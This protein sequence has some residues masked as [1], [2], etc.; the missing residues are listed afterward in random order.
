MKNNN[1]IHRPKIMGIL[2]VTPDS[3]S[4]GGKHNQ[5]M[6]A[7]DRVLRMLDQG[8][9]IIDIGG[10]STRPGADPVPAQEQ[11]NRVIPVIE[12]IRRSSK[13]DTLISVD[14]T[15]YLVATFALEAGANWINDVSAGEDS[16]LF[17]NSNEP[18][19]SLAA[20]KNVPIILMHSQGKSINMQDDPSYTDVCLE[21][22][23]Y[24]LERAKVALKMGVKKENIILD[25]GI[26]FGKLLKH[27]LELL[28]DLP[29]FTSMGYP[30]LL[31]TSRKRFIGEI[32]HQNNPEKRVAGTCATTALGVNAGVQIFRVH[33]IAENR[34]AADVAWQIKNTH[35]KHTPLFY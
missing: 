25:P 20:R 9:D 6:Q 2:N 26:G 11:I 14:T 32:S 12:A 5:P 31:G 1:K 30:I 4:D 29:A 10:E 15:D 21:V 28:A 27:N 3:F 23:K 8:A 7:V 24:L 35:T 16:R 13:K 33:D 18:M 22:K 34:Q 17:E 19:L